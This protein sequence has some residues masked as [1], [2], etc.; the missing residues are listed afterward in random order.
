MRA[1]TS[2][3]ETPIPPPIQECVRIIHIPLA[4]AVT[5][6]RRSA[7]QR[8]PD[9]FVGSTKHELLHESSTSATFRVFSVPSKPKLGILGR[10][11]T[12]VRAITEEGKLSVQWSPFREVKETSILDYRQREG[13]QPT[14]PETWGRLW[15]VR[16]LVPSG[17]ATQCRTEYSIELRSERA[18]EEWPQQLDRFRAANE[19]MQDIIV[20]QIEADYRKRRRKLLR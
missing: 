19:S 1:P 18:R 20:R 17:D 6:F 2:S 12:D 13:S 15:V 16:T 3:E 4:D 9:R 7:Y 5:W 11:P 10:V 14:T 8:D